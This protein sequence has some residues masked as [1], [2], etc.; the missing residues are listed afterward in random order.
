MILLTI[1][2]WYA[3]GSAVW[4]VGWLGF[5]F[6]F[7]AKHDAS[8]DGGLAYLFLSLLPLVGP[9]MLAHEA[10]DRTL[11]KLKMR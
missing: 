2:M 1:L 10:Y 9:W 8:G 7:E 6:L 3:I 5:F 4:F 11:R